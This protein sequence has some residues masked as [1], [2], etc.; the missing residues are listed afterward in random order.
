MRAQPVE[1]GVGVGV[2]DGFVEGGDEVVM[3][4][5]GLVVEEGAGSG[6]LRLRLFLGV[7]V[8]DRGRCELGG[9]FEGVEGG[10]G[11]SGGVGWRGV[12][13][14]LGW[15]GGYGFGGAR[16]SAARPGAPGFVS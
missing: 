8:W 6:R 5:A 7:M 15:L 14:L 2:A 10:A 4:L 11:V 9:Y 1:G 3:L 13:G 16:V 12:A